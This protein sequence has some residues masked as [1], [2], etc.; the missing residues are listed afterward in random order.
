MTISQLTVAA[1]SYHGTRTKP[2]DTND[3]I[4]GLSPTRV[5]LGI[6]DDIGIVVYKLSTDASLS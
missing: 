1:K 4:A 5:G 6:R 3:R 2:T